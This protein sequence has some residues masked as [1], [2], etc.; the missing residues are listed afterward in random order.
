[1]MTG[2]RNVCRTCMDETA[3]LVDIFANVRDPV[4]DEPEMSLSHIVA[5]CTDRPVKRG[6]LLPQYICLSCVLAVQN[7]FRF[8]WNSEQSYQHF[9]RLLNQS[10]SPEDQL[11]SIACNQDKNQTQKMQLKSD[12]QEDLQQM[13]KRQQPEHDLGEKHT[14]QTKLEENHKDSPPETFTPHRRRRTCRTEE[15]RDRIPKE[16]PRS[17]NIINPQVRCDANGYYKC[18]HCSK[19]FYSQTQLRTHISDLCNRCPYCPRSYKQKSNLKRHLRTHVAKPAHKCFH[20]SKAFMRKDHL[21]K[22]LSIHDSDGPLSCSQCS[23]VFIESVQLEIHRREHLLQA[24]SLKSESTKEPDSEVGDEAHDPKSNCTENSP[25]MLNPISDFSCDSYFA[26]ENIQNIFKQQVLRDGE[27]KKRGDVLPG[28]AKD[29]ADIKENEI[30]ILDRFR[31]PPAEKPKCH[32]CLKKFCSIY[33]LKRHMLT[34]NRPPDLRKC[35]YCFEEFHTEKHLKRHERGHSGELFRCEYCSL[36]FV[37][38]DYLRK[39]KKRIHSNNLIT[40]QEKIL[41]KRMAR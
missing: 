34:H 13:S 15:H 24:G 11:H 35:S 21:K 31:S 12:R 33:N 10:S 7:A 32:L 30:Q 36:V 8:K 4:L 6:D 19:R 22:H 39:H 20:C 23:A 40:I 27:L 18:P 5:R 14:L 37:D 9:F 41:S 29:G 28:T 17:T 16:A 25:T 2:A 38:V 26:K 3:T 1:M